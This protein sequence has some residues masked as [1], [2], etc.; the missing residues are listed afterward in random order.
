MAKCPTVKFSYQRL[1]SHPMYAGKSGEHFPQTNTGSQ[2]EG[3]A[4]NTSRKPL[5]AADC[6]VDTRW[7]LAHSQSA[8]KPKSSA[9]MLSVGFTPWP[10]LNRA[11]LPRLPLA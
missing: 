11:G 10:E 2:V 8:L 3:C 7:Q 1:I 4:K 5:A 6:C 9:A